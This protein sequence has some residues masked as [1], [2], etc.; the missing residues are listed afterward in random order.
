ML[1]SEELVFLDDSGGVGVRDF[2]EWF[3]LDVL[4]LYIGEKDGEM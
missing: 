4:G 2:V 1:D 3:W